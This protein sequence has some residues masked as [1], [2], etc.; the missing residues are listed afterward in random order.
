MLQQHLLVP[1]FP[2]TATYPQIPQV[3]SPDISLA[4]CGGS[5][6]DGDQHPPL[7]W[8]LLS[9]S[10]EPR[11]RLAHAAKICRYLGVS[12]SNDPRPLKDTSSIW[13][14]EWGLVGSVWQGVSVVEVRQ[15]CSV[16]RV[17]KLN[18]SSHEYYV[19]KACRNNSFPV[20]AVLDGMPCFFKLC[21]EAWFVARGGDGHTR[22]PSRAVQLVHLILN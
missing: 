21:G 2:R 4:A 18:G 15:C 1:D 9:S 6:G 19:R 10:R 7:Y 14:G 12:S 5:T 16:F 22:I 13:E 3:G 8:R 17:G 11:L 20:S